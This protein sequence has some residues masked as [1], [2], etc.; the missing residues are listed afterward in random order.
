MLL[1]GDKEKAINH[2]YDVYFEEARMVMLGNK[3]F[4]ID[5]N[6]FMI[7]DGVKHKDISDLVRIN[8]QKN[9]RRYYYIENN[10]LL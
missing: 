1:D 6:D 8:F 3:Y 7:V 10:K 2:V 4:D 5:I 9:S